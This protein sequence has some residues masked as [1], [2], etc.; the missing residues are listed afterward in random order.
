M[1]QVSR[2][3]TSCQPVP[4][5]NQNP[6]RGSSDWRY[7]RR[8][9]WRSGCAPTRWWLRCLC[10]RVRIQW[11]HQNCESDGPPSSVGRAQLG[12]VRCT[13]A[14]PEPLNDWRRV[15][16]FQ[17]CTKI[18]NKSYKVI[19]DNGR[20]INVVAS[21]LITI[22]GMRPVKHPNP[23]KVSWTDATPIDVQERCQ[24]SIQFSTYTD[25]M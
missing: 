15:A 10:W 25:N 23:Y 4:K 8:G 21:R 11:V 14:Q 22:L 6:L 18:K 17:T 3:W 5:S 2:V 24:I 19:V 9:W 1:L 20:C 7:R 13:L 12:V 16:I